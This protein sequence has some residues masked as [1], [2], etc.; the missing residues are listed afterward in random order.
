MTKKTE[1][2]EP[3]FK[4]AE[5]FLEGYPRN[6]FSVTLPNGMK[7]VILT[8]DRYG[9]LAHVEREYGPPRPIAAEDD[10]SEADV[11]KALK[12]QVERGPEPEV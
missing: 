9:E 2:V 6:P 11:L 1:F 4:K 5:E 10:M 12:D 3:D 8:E 7:A